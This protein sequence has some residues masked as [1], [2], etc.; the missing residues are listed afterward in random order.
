MNKDQVI[1]KTK[2]YSH[3][4][5]IDLD[6]Y[7]TTGENDVAEISTRLEN[8]A[9]DRIISAGGDGTIKMVASVILNTKV[10][11]GILACGSAN[12]LATSLN[13]P[14]ELDEQLEIA[15]KQE[16]TSIDTV[17][18]NDTI[19]VHISDLGLNA[20]LIYNYEKSKSSGKLGYAIQSVPT[21]IQSEAPYDF[22]ITFDD[23]VIKR[24]SVLLAMANAKKYGTGMVINP[25]G[26]I[27]DGHFEVIIFEKWNPKEIV[28]AFFHDF[29]IQKSAIELIQTTS[30]SIQ[31]KKPIP[32][33][34]DGEYIGEFEKISAQIRP[35]SLN[36]AIPN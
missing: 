35:N 29:T 13:I 25:D 10:V 33:Q 31:C 14:D 22:E 5:K 8:I 17:M 28:K 24:S 27:T 34:V 36:I 16:K 11:L 19:C 21:L 2:E 15:F 3:K 9:F 7:C 26:S 1:S 18:I 4:C 12:G 6:I 20:E 30:I 23:R 32:L